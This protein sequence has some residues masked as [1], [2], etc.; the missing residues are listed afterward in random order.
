MLIV[1]RP[2]CPE[3]HP[4]A[5]DNGQSCCESPQKSS[6]P[7]QALEYTDT[8]AECSASVACPS[9]ICIRSTKVMGKLVG[10]GLFRV[11]IIL[12]HPCVIVFL[13]MVSSP[14]EIVSFLLISFQ[15]LLSVLLLILLLFTMGAFAVGKT[16]EL[17]NQVRF[18]E[19]K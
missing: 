6:D 7:T 8:S 18:L 4:L 15:F 17:V 14:C 16:H 10:Q 9:W 12:L 2:E 11:S 1:D 5:F 19:T 13:H 3:D